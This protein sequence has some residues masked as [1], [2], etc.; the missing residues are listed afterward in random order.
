MDKNTLTG[1]VLIG[2]LLTLFTVF[3]RPTEEE[4]K[5]RQKTELDK[6]NKSKEKVASK[7]S[8]SDNKSIDASSNAKPD[9]NDKGNVSKNTM[10]QIDTIIGKN[11][12]ISN[13]NM[14][15]NLNSKGGIINSVFLKKYVTYDE[16]ANSSAPNLYAYLMRVIILISSHLMM[17]KRT[18]LLKTYFLLQIKKITM[19]FHLFIK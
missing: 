17:V 15:V 6:N 1:L 8:N 2:L 11:H 16:F 14:V 13:N 7:E 4:I 9:E 19:R 12:T 18:Y 5:E 3:N 10:P